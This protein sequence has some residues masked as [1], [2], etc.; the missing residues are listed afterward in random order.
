MVGYYLG[1]LGEMEWPVEAGFNLIDADGK[2]VFH[3]PLTRRS[4]VGY[5]YTPTPYQ[6]VYQ[7][8]F[9]PFATSGIYRL[10][11]PG[12]GVSYPFAIDDGIAADFARTYA[13]GLYHQRCGMANELPFTRFTHAACHLA[14]AEAP[15]MSNQAVNEELAEMTSDFHDNPRHTA[16]QLKNIAASL[17]PFVRTGKVDVSGGHHDAGDYSKY[18]IDVAQLIHTLVFAADAFPGAGDLDNLGIPES[19]DG[20]SDLLEEAKWEADFL[21][22]MQD[23]DGGFYFLVYPR[24]REYE[25]N[26]SLVGRD[27]GD[28][29]IV[30]PKTTGA[31][32]AAVAALA[33]MSSSPLFKKQF[34]QAAALYLQNARKGWDFLQRAIAKFGRDGSY[35][36]ITHYG[37][38]FMHDD[39]LAW[40][41]TEMFL[42]TGDPALQKLVIAHLHPDDP[43]QRR[44]TWWRL[45]ESYGCATRSFAFAARTKR[46]PVEQLD[47]ILLEQCENEII[48]TADDALRD[49]ADNAYGTSFPLASKQFRDAGWYFSLDHAFDLAVAYQLNYPV[50]NDPRPKYLAALLANLNYE[51]GCNPVNMPFVTGV[52]WRRQRNIV[53]QYAENAR[54][55]LAPTGLEIGNIQEGF[56]YL[57]PYKKELSNLT[58]PTDWNE[59]NPYPF[60][61]RW[62]DAFNTTTESV[63]V[64]MGRGLAA[65]AFLMGQTKLAQQ[66]WRCA[67]ARLEAAAGSPPQF[68][69]R[70]DAAGMDLKSARCVWEAGGDPIILDASAPFSPPP[71]AEWVEAEAWWPD[72]RRVF[73]S[74]NLE[75]GRLTGK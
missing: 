40:A 52:G 1:N 7:A 47:Q 67:P 16:P 58:F 19:G 13:L 18:T 29:Q 23:S 28:P 26:V 72:G 57:D 41:E 8:D 4:D 6:N 51:G 36:K 12:L 34:P 46:L 3:G 74:T 14:P 54:R 11:I 27:T 31:T 17:Y 66:P 21:V 24:D 20:K 61:D 42:A 62:A 65:T 37:D 38:E 69:L 60:Y 45:F 71:G 53:N 73:I 30:Y 39:E 10:Q 55:A 9:S 44:W 32:A 56:M 25:D 64:N 70:V 2:V 5:T 59:I 33:E 49:S 50:M 15:T 43:A 22:K 68:R 35:Q 75:G 48:A 63:T